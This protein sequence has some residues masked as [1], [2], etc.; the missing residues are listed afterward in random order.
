MSL[1]NL[2]NLLSSGEFV[3]FAGAGV[4]H[5]ADLPDWKSLAKDTA[6]DLI[7]KS[8]LA[9]DFLD[10]Q[11]HFIDI[12]IPLFF[13]ILEASIHVPGRRTEMIT[14]IRTILEPKKDSETIKCLNKIR[15]LG[16]ITTNYDKLTNSITTDNTWTL[17]NSIDDLKNIS[18]A[19]SDPAWQFIFK[20]HGDI[21]NISSP[22][23]PSVIGGAPFMVLTSSDYTAYLQRIDYIKTV[24]HTLLV[25]SPIIFLGYSFNDP[26]IKYA[27]DILKEYCKFKHSSYYI[28]LDG[29]TQ[30][31]LPDN[32][33]YETPISGWE[34]LP[35]WLCSI[36]A[37][38]KKKEAPKKPD[39]PDFT[40]EDMKALSALIEYFDSIESDD[41]NV[42]ALSSIL[43]SH[44]IGK[45]SSTKEELSEVIR[46]FLNIGP[47]WADSYIN[48]VIKQLS[49]LGVIHGSDDANTFVIQPQL[50]VLHEKINSE[51]EKEKDDFYTSIRLRIS[52]TMSLTQEFMDSID[53]SL[54][55]L[56]FLY[57]E[58]IAH[59][60][61]QGYSF[62]IDDD[63]ISNIL[64][65]N[66]KDSDLITPAMGLIKYLLT[67]PKKEELPYLYRL[68]SSSILLNVIKLKPEA[69]RY[70]KK[71]ISN[72]HIYLDS[73]I[74]LP[75]IIEEHNNHIWIKSLIKLSQKAGVS[76]FAL[77][78]FVEEVEGHR[79]LAYDFL[80]HINGDKAAVSQFLIANSISS[81]C[82]V[83]GYVNSLQKKTI[84]W[85][86]YLSKYTISNIK[87]IIENK[88]RIPIK[89]IKE[90]FN[91]FEYSNILELIEEEWKKKPY[92]SHRNPALNKHEA[93]QFLHIYRERQIARAQE[94]HDDVWFLSYETIF[95]KVFKKDPQKWLKPPTFSIAAWASFIDSYVMFDEDISARYYLFKSLVGSSS[96]SFDLPEPIDIV[97]RKTFG[98]RP[99][100]KEE[101]E[102]LQVTI[103]GGSLIT[104][105]EAARA[106]IKK[107]DPKHNKWNADNYFMAAG[108]FSDSVDGLSKEVLSELREK[109]EYLKSNLEKE[110]GRKNQLEEK[111]K[112]LEKLHGNAR[113]NKV[114][115]KRKKKS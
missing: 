40:E 65:Q 99:I 11:G 110:T 12:N 85:D 14:S 112:T 26:D 54:F 71:T 44:L 17:S 32:V 64:G 105:M 97:K 23:E 101:M 57:G 72:Y 58:S 34:D 80:R 3:L 61:H 115:K 33:Q 36:Q 9:K 25:Q 108:V 46:N 62:D 82:F 4:C 77:N 1:T 29:E 39:T 84:T 81:N 75:L 47:K 35:S 53:R 41:I 93:R 107:I 73:N 27:L 63:I 49:A 48:P 37:K 95:E 51:R 114:R 79:D 42:K 55:E 94:S 83:T 56:C 13:E 70:I 6:N 113:T 19:S 16:V 59:T 7:V 66:I 5:D 8:M 50:D 89:T 60:I 86:S 96:T 69:S 68:L 87:K 15:P 38:S 28:G 45:Q 18:V 10:T 100:S 30:P 102:A 106:Q 111:I 76:I 21:D 109:I 67:A 92:V 104:K 98:A 2:E 88:Y 90:D 78:D 74:L 20:V 24:F 22:S 43:A 91:E 31:A 52:K 103:S